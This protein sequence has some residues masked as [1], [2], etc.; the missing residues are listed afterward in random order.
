MTEERS[1]FSSLDSNGS[2]HEDIVF[3]DNNKGKVMGLG[4]IDIT[5]DLSISNVLLVKP[6]SYNLLSISQ[7]CEMGFNCLFTDVD[8]MV[9]RRNDSSVAFKGYAKGKLYLVDFTSDKA[10]LQTCLMAK[11]NKGWLWHQ[12]LAHVGMRNLHKL[13][14]GDHVL[15][16]MNVSF[17]KNKICSACQTGKQVGAQHPSKN[18]MTTSRPLEMLHMDLFGPIAYISI[19]GNQYGLVIL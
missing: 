16:L 1:M 11:T 6:L 7:L 19:G 18:V 15:G 4:K 2:P 12:R 17:E 5:N 10:K 3:G 14:K 9:F 13:L 8:V